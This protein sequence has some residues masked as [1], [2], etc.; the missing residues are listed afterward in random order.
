[1]NIPGRDGNQPTPPKFDPPGD[2]HGEAT[3]ANGYMLTRR[4]KILIVED[5]RK[6]VQTVRLYLEHAGFAVRAAHDGRRALEEA[7][8]ESYDLIIL[9]L[10]LP[11]VGGIEVCRQLRARSATPIVMLTAKA[12]EEDK[13]SGLEM[14]ADDYVA[15]PFSPRELVARVRAVLRRT[16]PAKEREHAESSPPVRIND[17]TIDLE[18]REVRV[19]NQQ[20]PLTPTEF[21]LLETFAGS[22]RRVFTRRELLERALGWDYDGFERTV[23]A[24]IRNLRRK[25]DLD[26]LR[27][28][29]IT[30]V[31]GVGYKLAEAE[32]DS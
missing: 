22:P 1:M 11:E 27:P 7:R 28:S 4:Q 20:V 12:T 18:S 3:R 21:K 32:D 26:A 16:A 13:L 31:F 30:T 25:I 5:D 10:M 17:L 15:K 8:N 9:D 23:D 24:H 14:G 2:T 19:G 6:T 29:R